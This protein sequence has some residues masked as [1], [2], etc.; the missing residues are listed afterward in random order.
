METGSN[1]TLHDD[2]VTLESFLHPW[3]FWGESIGHRWINIAKGQQCGAWF[4]CH[5]N[6]LLNKP[7]SDLRHNEPQVKSC[8]W[9]HL[10]ILECN[11]H[12]IVRQHSWVCT[13]VVIACY[14]QNCA[15]IKRILMILIV[16]CTETTVAKSVVI[17]RQFVQICCIDLSVHYV[18]IV[19]T[20][21]K[22]LFFQENKRPIWQLYY[23]SSTDIIPGDKESHNLESVP[24]RIEWSSATEKIQYIISSAMVTKLVKRLTAAG[25]HKERVFKNYLTNWGRDEIDAILQTTFWSAFSWLKMFEFRLKFHWSL[26][27]I[28]NITALVQI[29]VQ[30]TS[31]H[32]NWSWLVY[33]HIYAPLGL[34]GFN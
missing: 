29:M 6:K 8:L 10:F 12:L 14:V 2:F 31:H 19:K 33:R 32:L 15:T 23:N 7:S 21:C 16:I 3:L 4:F 11:I 28:N 25:Y 18:K 13:T 9:P 20:K 5:L 1:V 27:P 34:N 30:A 26:F 17:K 24:Y 22:T